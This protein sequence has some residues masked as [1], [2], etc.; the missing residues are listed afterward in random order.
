MAVNP[1]VITYGPV[2]RCPIKQAEPSHDYYY[3]RDTEFGFAS[4]RRV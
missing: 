1:L 3:E 2:Q 4:G